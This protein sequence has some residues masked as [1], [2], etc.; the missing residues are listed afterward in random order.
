[1]A[2]VAQAP[3]QP[4]PDFCQ[5]RLETYAV[6]ERMNQIILERLNPLLI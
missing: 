2:R 6:N 4:P 1:M 3:A 5:A